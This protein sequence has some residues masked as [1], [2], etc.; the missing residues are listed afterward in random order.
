M[1]ICRYIAMLT[2]AVLLGSTAAVAAKLGPPLVEE[3]IASASD[4]EREGLFKLW[5][6][7]KPVAFGV[8]LTGDETEAGRITALETMVRSRLRGARIFRDEPDVRAHHLS[9]RKNGFL[10]V[11][12]HQQGDSALWFVRFE[13]LMVELGTDLIGWANAGWFVASV[14][15]GNSVLADVSPQ[16]DRFVDDYLRVNEVACR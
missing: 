16:I 14:S 1:R 7:C 2:M 11:L 9:L 5:N 10:S 12:V 13:K 15:H 6:D 3:I 4:E 8:R